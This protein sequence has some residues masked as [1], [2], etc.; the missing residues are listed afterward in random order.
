[1]FQNLCYKYTN[2]KEWIVSFST[3]RIMLDETRIMPVKTCQ[4]HLEK[5]IIFCVSLQI[6]IITSTT[7]DQTGICIW[8]PKL[9]CATIISKT[10]D[11]DFSL[12]N[13]KTPHWFARTKLCFIK[14]TESAFFKY[15]PFLLYHMNQKPIGYKSAP[16]CMEE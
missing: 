13:S 14:K 10:V 7:G 15:L 9:F 2:R 8:Y 16:N 11:K 4:K 6:Q 3:A 1:M 12:P 5:N